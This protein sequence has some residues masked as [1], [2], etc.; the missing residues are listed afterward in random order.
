MCAIKGHQILFA[1]PFKEPNHTF[2]IKK[3]DHKNALEYR[4]SGHPILSFRGGDGGIRTLEG[5]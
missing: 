1:D 3:R 4:H 2:P 5:R